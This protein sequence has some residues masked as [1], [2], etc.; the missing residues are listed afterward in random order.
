MKLRWWMAA[1]ATL[2]FAG[3]GG[4][5]A[6]AQDHPQE[7]HEHHWD[8]HNPRFDGTST[9]WSTTGG[10]IITIIRLSVF[11]LR[12]VCPATGIPGW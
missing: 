2:L 6:R 12:I 11:G 4:T 1:C 10:C 7:Q 3:L 9:R 5:A 8:A